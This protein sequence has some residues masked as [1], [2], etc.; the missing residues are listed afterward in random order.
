[1]ILIA[2]KPM[3]LTPW[4]RVLP[5]KLTIP[6][7]VKKLPTFYETQKFITAFTRS[8]YLSLS[9]ARSIQ[10]MPPIPLLAHPF[11]YYLAIYAYKTEMF[12]VMLIR[13]PLGLT[14]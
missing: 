5:E 8:C 1:M 14:W 13:L 10:S 12:A 4:S 6:Q 9:W 3:S 2:E 7:L 11:E